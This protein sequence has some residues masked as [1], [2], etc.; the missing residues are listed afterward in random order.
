MKNFIEKTLFIF[1]PTRVNIENED[2]LFSACS[3]P[4]D[5]VLVIVLGI[6]IGEIAWYW[7]RQRCVITKTI[8]KTVTKTTLVG[9]ERAL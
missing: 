5:V 7:E 1:F 2:Y 9:F 4:T 6:V 3:N 8:F